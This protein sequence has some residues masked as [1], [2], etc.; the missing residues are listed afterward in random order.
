[1]N[2]KKLYDD[3]QLYL[4]IAKQRRHIVLESLENPYQAELLNLKETLK[5]DKFLFYHQMHE[6]I[7]RKIDELEILKSKI[8]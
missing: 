6:D 1:M 4:E 3:M 2:L 8:Q 5:N 7:Y